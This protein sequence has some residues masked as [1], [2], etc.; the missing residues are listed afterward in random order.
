MLK[1][2]NGNDVITAYL[3]G[4]I[5]QHN[6]KLIREELDLK[7]EREMPKKLTLDFSGVNFIDS[8]GIGLVLG[9]YKKML[10]MGGRTVLSGL[11]QNV[12]RIMTL[13]GIDKILEL[14]EE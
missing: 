4:E 1:F 12:K 10:V 11:N 6:A 13:G 9:R 8:S 7:I 3:S 14:E 5:D 2:E